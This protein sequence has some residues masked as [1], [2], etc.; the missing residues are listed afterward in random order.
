MTTLIIGSDIEEI[1]RGLF[2]DCTNLKSIVFSEEFRRIGDNAFENCP[3][4]VNVRLTDISYIG[5]EAFMNCTGLVSVELGSSI[6]H[7]GMG[8]FK[9]CSSLSSVNIPPNI[10]FMGDFSFAN[11]SSLKNVM[12][13]DGGLVE[14]PAYA[15]QNCTSLEQVILPT[16]VEKVASTAFENCPN[17][18]VLV[19][20]LN[21]EEAEELLG[22]KMVQRAEEDD[23]LFKSKE[24]YVVRLYKDLY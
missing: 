12:V 24:G 18:E 10:S 22:T 19:P 21:M 1:E 20:T 6:Q 11:C 9:N 4:L 16:G 5:D 14:I 7:I 3:G 8:A 15:F 2:K 13:M 23:C 17:V